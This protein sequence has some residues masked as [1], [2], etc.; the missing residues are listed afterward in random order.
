MSSQRSRP[1]EHRAD[2][3][4]DRRQLGKIFPAFR[5]HPAPLV[6]PTSGDRCAAMKRKEH[7]VALVVHRDSFQRKLLN[8][9]PGT[10]APELKYRVLGISS[11][12]RPYQTVGESDGLGESEIRLALRLFRECSPATPVVLVDAVLCTQYWLHIVDGVL[13][14][15]EV[16]PLPQFDHM[17]SSVRFQFRPPR[18]FPLGPATRPRSS[19]DEPEGTP[20]P[21]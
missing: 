13:Q 4:I 8:P 10:P 11:A 7:H 16:V 18:Q 15:V 5:A 20:R 9:A 21:G 17:E 2:E 12:N 1:P 3:L 19:Q 6:S 14:I